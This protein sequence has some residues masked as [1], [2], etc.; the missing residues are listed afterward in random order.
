VLNTNITEESK[1]KVY[2]LQT[3]QV[4]IDF[5]NVTEELQKI[6]N[7]LSIRDYYSLTTYYRIFI[8]DMF[9]E[10][11]KVLYLDSDTIVTRDVAELYH[12]HLGD[13]YMGAVQDYL[14]RSVKIYGDYV[15]KVLGISRAAYFN[16]GVALINSRMFRK[17]KIKNQFIDLLN[18]YTF[19]VAQDQDYL[20]ILCQ[21]H[22]LW[23]DS[24]W[25]V[26]MT[27]EKERAISDT[28]IIHYN[29]AVKPWQDEN[30]RYGKQFWDVAAQTAYY[31]EIQEVRRNFGE[32][33]AQKV[34]AA[35][36]NLMH[37]ALS[38]ILN[39]DNYY[40][41]F[42]LKEKELSREEV[43]ALREQYESEGRFIEDLEADPPSRMLMP[44][45]V[46]YLRRN[47]TNRL[48][49]K[50]AFRFAR[51]F[52]NTMIRKKLLV[53]KEIKGIENYKSLTSGA[54]ITCNHFNAFDSFAMQIAYEK[55]FPRTNPL[56]RKFF[57]IIKEGN[58]T[59]FPGFYGFLMR[60]CNTLPLSSNKDT[61]KKFMRA[62]DR[63]LQK[64]H[65]IL[66][67]PE[68]SMWWNYRKPKP[69]RK[70]GYTFAV[71][72]DVPVLPCFVTMEDTDMPG[73][74]GYPV[75]AYTIHIAPP[76]YPDKNLK[77]AEN[78][79]MMMQKNADAWKKAYEDAYGIPLE[80]TCDDSFVEM[81]K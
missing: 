68:Q 76:I 42:V 75:Q 10:Y 34:E 47:M 17:E 1:Q 39:E 64:G 5:C 53:I 55:A 2:E 49:T 65:L 20:N 66:I 15:E 31:D 18:T 11:D 7:K 3:E 63:I 77:K 46:D 72:N 48:R 6:A 81:Y 79:Q 37:L 74:G 73:E 26:Q 62:V 24:M 44:D 52:M 32:K 30:C 33:D 21:N 23:I 29:L 54:I 60:N 8:A 45:E 57:R 27:E 22:V 9:P 36:Q 59:S 70:G 4:T 78:V 25:N 16:A 67:Y 69:L 56:R 40:N 35:G 38:E 50:Y 28:G 19:V 58:Y 41:R 13:N 61:M 51:W 14:V 80:Y 12:Y 43:I 71:N